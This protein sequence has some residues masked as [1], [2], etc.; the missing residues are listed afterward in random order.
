MKLIAKFSVILLSIILS[1]SFVNTVS[2][3]NDC[4][5]E[6]QNSCKKFLKKAKKINGK[7]KCVKY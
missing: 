7:C 1:F 5:I 6:K 3:A 2:A 4:S